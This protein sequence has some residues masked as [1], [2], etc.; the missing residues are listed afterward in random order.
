MSD[1][2]NK[3]IIVGKSGVG[4]DYITKIFEDLGKE[5]LVTYTTRPQRYPG[6]D[7]HKF[8]TEQ[9][10]AS[11]ANSEKYLR[12]SV[13]QHEYFTTLED[14]KKADVIIL[15]PAGVKEILSRMPDQTFHLI[16]I[17]ADPAE[18]MRAALLRQ[19]R[20]F[21]RACPV[22][23]DKLDYIMHKTRSS[24]VVDSYNN[25]VSEAIETIGKFSKYTSFTDEDKNTL[26]KEVGIVY[27]RF[28]DEEQ[29]FDDFEH[30]F[31]GYVGRRVETPDNVVFVW[32][33]TNNF[34][35]SDI[36][37]KVQEIVR[38]D[39]M[40]KKMCEKNFCGINDKGDGDR[41]L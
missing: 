22:L 27:S 18:R 20:R 39:E 4:K 12:T 19:D 38:T 41:G 6:E 15:D 40:A 31:Y 14:V 1:F 9:E 13:A 34:D 21:D 17:N 3:F 5:R 25:A 33:I 16:Y 32:D 28:V 23:S 35:P 8:I 29:A 26:A 7:T 24:K 10:A 11:F 36:R 30:V 37:E 2:N